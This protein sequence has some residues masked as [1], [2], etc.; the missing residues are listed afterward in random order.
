M[1]KKI[2]L[3]LMLASVLTACDKADMSKSEADAKAALAYEQIKEKV[4]KESGEKFIEQAKK[5]V[6]FNLK[7]PDSAQFRNIRQP[8]TGVVCGEVNAKNAMGGYVGFQRFE[9]SLSTPEYVSIL[10]DTD[11]SVS[12]K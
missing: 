12:C 10:R 9:W 5:A 1:N 2:L 8:S 3:A 4:E 11:T 7:D 6:R